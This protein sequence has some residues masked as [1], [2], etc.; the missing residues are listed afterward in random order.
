MEPQDDPEARIRELERPLADVARA[1][2]LGGANYT[3]DGAGAP[4]PS[5]AYGAPYATAPRTA[6]GRFRPWWLVLAL[7]AVA[8]LILAVG[9]AVFRT[10]MSPRGGFGISAPDRQPSVL[11][12]GGSIDR[13]PGDQPSTSGGG[14]VANAPGGQ[15]S[16]TGSGSVTTP[17]PGGLLSVSG[18]GE[19]KTIACN[20]SFVSVSGVSNTVT[21][22]GHCMSLTVSGMRN[23]VTVGTA[24]TI[25]ASG[26]DNRI[27]YLSGSPRIENSGLSNLVQQG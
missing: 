23:L 18:M 6:A 27:N 5:P 21:I 11:G 7:I 3:S 14:S 1:T 10:T 16:T 26:L 4:T 22:T 2:E 13:G 24:D 12:G 25:S 9:V 20:D 19:T 8:V 15:P 17:P